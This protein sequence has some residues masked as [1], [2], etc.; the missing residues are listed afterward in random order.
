MQVV[1]IVIS[2]LVSVVAITLF[3]RAALRIV[4]V[5]RLGQ[6]ILGRRDSPGSR[7]S[8][9]ASGCWTAGAGTTS[10]CTCRSPR[11]GETVDRLLAGRI[12][13]EVAAPPAPEPGW[14]RP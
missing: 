12:V 11:T 3:V 1:A 14:P 4:R 9:R 5:L 13:S 7:W 2:L 6:P 10:A 8:T